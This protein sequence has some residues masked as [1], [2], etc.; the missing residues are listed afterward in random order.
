MSH[1][2][3]YRVKST[4]LSS[5]NIRISLSNITCSTNHALHWADTDGSVKSRT[6]A[7]PRAQLC[8]PTVSLFLLLTFHLLSLPYWFDFPCY[9]IPVGAQY[10]QCAHCPV[11]LV[12]WVRCAL[13]S[14]SRSSVIHISSPNSRRSFLTFLPRHFI[15][16]MRLAASSHCPV[17]IAL[18]KNA[19]TQFCTCAYVPDALKPLAQTFEC[20]ISFLSIHNAGPLDL[21]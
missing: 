19:P 8:F 10:R 4:R 20:P 12:D 6:A 1:F 11:W 16:A 7:F 21:M 15:L 9:P 14:A 13:W 18:S 2:H 5:C 3:M 17:P